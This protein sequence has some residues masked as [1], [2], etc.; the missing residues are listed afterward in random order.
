VSC[1]G[2]FRLAPPYI[3]RFPSSE[4]LYGVGRKLAFDVS[5]LSND[6]FF[7]GRRAAWRLKKGS[8]YCLVKWVTTRHNSTHDVLKEGVF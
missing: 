6:P 8:K 5:G 4:I 1:K 3:I 7:R 2:D